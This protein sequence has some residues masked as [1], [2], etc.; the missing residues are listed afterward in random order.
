MEKKTELEYFEERE[1][2]TYYVSKTFKFS[3][4]SP[5]R[6]F[7]NKVFDHSEDNRIEKVKVTGEYVLRSSLSHRDQIKVLILQDN[8]E[9]RD[10]VLQKFV[11]NNPYPEL[12]LNRT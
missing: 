9:I 7:I 1:P 4:T 6:R 5:E 11:N 3:E 10:L 2:D 12:R 8:K